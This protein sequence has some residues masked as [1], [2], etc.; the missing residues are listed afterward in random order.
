[1]CEAVFVRPFFKTAIHWTFYHLTYIEPDSFVRWHHFY[2]R[3]GLSV[4]N[5]TL[6]PSV[7]SICD[8]SNQE[9][10]FCQ[11]KKSVGWTVFLLVFNIIP[12]VEGNGIKTTISHTLNVWLNQDL[13]TNFLLRSLSSFS[14]KF[15]LCRASVLG[16][17]NWFHRM[18]HW[19]VPLEEQWNQVFCF[20]IQTDL[21]MCS[22]KTRKIL[23]D[24]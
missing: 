11:Q 6:P 24:V 21:Q 14:Y 2:V 20:R 8:S 16:L 4:V 9:G 15:W 13:I 5:I 10:Y 12:Y 17:F 7:H 18:T 3:V 23:I 22:L 19:I 1:M